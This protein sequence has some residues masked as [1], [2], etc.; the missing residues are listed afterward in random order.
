MSFQTFLRFIRIETNLA[1]AFPAILGFLFS[2]YYFHEFSWKVSILYFIALML[3]AAFVT[4]WN[5]VMDFRLAKDEEYRDKHNLLSTEHISQ[6][7][8]FTVLGVMISVA[9]IIGIA[10]IFMTNLLLLPI[11]GVCVLVTIFYTFSPFAFSRMPLGE[12]LAGF[13][14]GLGAFFL[15]VFVN[16]WDK[17]FM[18]LDVDWS[19]WNY[20]LHGNILLFITVILSGIACVVFNFNIMLADNICDLDQDVKNERY[21]LPYYLGKKNALKLFHFMYWLPYCTVTLSVILG[22][23]PL[24]ALIVWLTVPLIKKNVDIFSKEQIKSKTFIRAIQN[25]QIFEGAWII[26]MLLGIIFM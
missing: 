9:L 5:N 25:L 15:A 4:G 7:L 8:A 10:L 3:V 24:T 1:S 23:L 12:L 2:I 26:G 19:T 21:T 13:V 18:V 6:K 11:G 17:E 14:E 16:T 20:S 22:F